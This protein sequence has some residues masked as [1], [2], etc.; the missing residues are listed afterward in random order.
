MKK[1]STLIKIAV[2][3]MLIVI[4]A[5]SMDIKK[6]AGAI[7]VFRLPYSIPALFLIAVAVLISAFKWQVLL[8]AQGIKIPVSKLFKYYTAGF[9][10]NNFLPSSIGCDGIRVMLLKN[11]LASAGPPAQ[12]SL[13]AYAG[14]ASSVV[15]ERILAMATLGLLGL[16]GALFASA[17]S[18]VAMITLACVCAAGFFSMAVQFT[19]FTPKFIAQKETKLATI[20]KSFASSSA[21]L[22]KKPFHI[23]ICLAES[24]LFQMFVAFAQ[25]AIILGLG[26]PAL[27]LGDLFYVSAGASVLAMIPLGVNGY[28]FREGGFIYLLEPLGYEG[29]GAFAISL[30]FA[31]FVSVY[32]LLGAW[33]WVRAKKDKGENTPT[34]VSFGTGRAAT[35]ASVHG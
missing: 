32:S 28:G 16:V 22:R 27:A 10:F 23:L 20:W 2:S 26:L 6:I 7:G 35:G 19:G 21:E 8:K 4:L 11:E 24:I 31:L 29:S 12:P 9:F 17:P 33:F 25:Q 30:L 13:A 3:A 18:R 14:V 15:A 1:F 5:L 34:P